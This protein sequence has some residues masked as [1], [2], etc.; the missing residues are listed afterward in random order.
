MEN[1]VDYEITARF[2]EQTISGTIALDQGTQ[3]QALLEGI[4]KGFVIVGTPR[5]P[6]MINFKVASCVSIF[7][8]IPQASHDPGE[9]S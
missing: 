1:K 7:T 8:P 6:V 3:T 9:E 4:E 2:G 5:G